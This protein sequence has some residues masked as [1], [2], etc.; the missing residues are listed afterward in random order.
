MGVGPG[1]KV[2]EAEL[3]RSA[4]PSR[5]L[6]TRGI[7]TSLKETYM[8]V[9]ILCLSVLACHIAVAEEGNWNQFRGPHA[10]GTTTATN[11]PVTFAE[12]SPEIVW[13][14]PIP[15]RA[16]SSPV[17]W[18]KQIWVTNAP[19]LENKRTD[20]PI[21][22]KSIEKLEK[23]VELSAV[24]IDFDTGKVIHDIKLF[25]VYFLQVT[26]VTN[27]YASP[28][29]YIEE[30]RVYVHFGAYGTACLDTKTGKKIWERT[31]LECNHFRG[32]GSSPIVY[33][34]LLYLTFDGYDFQYITALDKMTGKTVWKR[35]RDIDYGTTDGD[36]K[37]AYSTPILINA[38]GRDLLISPFAKATIAYDPK[39]GEPV[40][41]VR[42]GGMNAAGRPLYGHGLLYITTA[43]GQNPMIAVDPKGQGDI[44]DH[45]V[46]RSNKSIPKRPSQILLGDL[47]FMVNDGGVA[48]CVEAK[49][50]AEVWTHRL[51]GEFWASPLSANG[52][53]YAFS[54]AGMIY[55][56]KAGREFELVAE[57][58]LGSGFLASPAVVG[59]SLVLRSKTHLYRIEKPRR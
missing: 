52:L 42:H 59:N 40:W 26:H 18:G 10:D 43:D 7:V 25:D 31:D 3:Q 35:N 13:K 2:K 33:G 1:L 19:E 49:T 6:G 39:S 36:A 50:N 44:T 54:Q 51:G 4:F 11:L 12:G 38:D 22:D 5:G 55:V 8:R 21:T 23:P 17:V 28:T 30:G 32:P 34:D 48:S 58:Q 47:L 9:V 46:W 14:T 37:K 24:C 16:W 57:N 45:I 56:F 41:T 29:P 20:K 53:I 27:S 15:G